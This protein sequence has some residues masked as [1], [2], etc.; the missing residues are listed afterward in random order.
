MRHRLNEVNQT[1]LARAQAVLN[2]LTDQMREQDPADRHSRLE[3]LV[4]SLKRLVASLIRPR[5]TKRIIAPFSLPRSETIN[6]TF[7]EVYED[8]HVLAQGQKD[9]ASSIVAHFNLAQ[10][11]QQRLSG[12]LQR[13]GKRL[14][15]Y[16]A[17]SKNL[18]HRRLTFQE[19][20]VSDERIAASSAHIR[21][22]EGIVTLPISGYK[23]YS[24]EAE[25]LHDGEE[26]AASPE[27]S[28]PGNFFV[29]YQPVLSQS[30]KAA[31]HIS[32]EASE[33]EW[34]FYHNHDPRDDLQAALDGRPD[35]WFEWQ[36]IN[37]PEEAKQPNPPPPYPDTHGYNWT[38]DDG[39]PIYYGDPEQDELRLRL[40]VDLKEMR[41]IN[42]LALHPYF[43]EGSDGFL[44][45][46]QVATSEDG[47]SF[48]PIPDSQLRI[49]AD[50]DTVPP[51]A[52]LGVDR[53]KLRG[54][55]V[56][57]FPGRTCRYVRFHLR[58]PQ[59][60][61]A[62]IG[63]LY[64]SISYDVVTQT[65]Y[66]F[67][68]KGKEKRERRTER[69][70]GPSLPRDAIVRRHEYT[71]THGLEGAGL[72]LVAMSL[73]GLGPIAIVVSALLGL[74]VSKKQWVENQSD[75]EPHW[76][77]YQDGWR[78][79]IGVRQ[80]SVNALTYGDYGS[81]AT[82][83][84]V[85]PQGVRSVS[86]SVDEEIPEEFYQND[87]R[88]RNQ[89]IR[90]FISADGNHWHPISP[91]E[92]MPVEEAPFPPKVYSGD[93]KLPPELGEGE[94]GELEGDGDITK[95]YVKIELSRPPGERYATMTPVLHSFT[96]N[97]VP[98]E[99]DV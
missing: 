3:A 20:F 4:S 56:W 39:T 91:L 78:W 16:M 18:A 33:A 47:V 37:V 92:H 82:K 43:P 58:S 97:V 52:S 72:G 9:L 98:K 17:M 48:T 15:D 31:K 25:I 64:Y 26:P 8:L 40:T 32:G 19:Q 89:W 86:L 80:I 77:I 13:T 5:F 21:Y 30:D 76:D 35:T 14:A 54:H 75:P 22:Q 71:K 42:W 11:E 34:D 46:D 27:F 49:A 59:S 99:A 70:E 95:L 6:A 1:I 88:T 53:E 29:A 45:V 55:G 96:L 93:P 57:S 85:V 74:L 51:N 28:M 50:A 69:I 60:Y 66:L 79:V 83:A 63:H 81:V 38:F 10:A 61:P 2:S 7:Q 65:T 12:L 62:A 87:L 23:D 84:F 94:R 90:Y 41:T 67:V 68:F 36:M 44:L 24:S 73:F